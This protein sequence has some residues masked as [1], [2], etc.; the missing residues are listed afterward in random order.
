M[1]YTATCTGRLKLETVPQPSRASGLSIPPQC[2]A[3][4][5][6]NGHDPSP[7]PLIGLQDS[8][9]W[10]PQYSSPL[11]SLPP[12]SLSNNLPRKRRR[13]MPPLTSW[14]G[15]RNSEPCNLARLT[16]SQ[17]P[18]QWPCSGARLHYFMGGAKRFGQW[19]IWTQFLLFDTN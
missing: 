9:W 10:M 1:N 4:C 18:S 16:Q 12:L 7:P 2:S 17:I 13:R 6:F 14:L 15:Q 5:S 11:F 19:S 8:S 3:H